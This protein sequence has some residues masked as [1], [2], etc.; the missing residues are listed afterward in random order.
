MDGHDRVGAIV[1]AAEHLLGLGGFD[2][3]LQLVEA[4]REIGVD[5]FASVRPLEQHAEIVGSPLQRF[6]ERLIFL[7]PP[8]ALH[9]LLRLVLVVPE[10]GRV[11]ALFYFGKLF[12]KA[13]TL[14]DTSGVPPR[15]GSNHHDAL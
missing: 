6:E 10:P 12:V 15:A 2:L 4:T 13:G 1:F 9:H 7:D 5:V 3:L 14:K 8:P 11:D